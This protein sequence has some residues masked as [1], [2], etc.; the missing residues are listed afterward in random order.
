M[1]IKVKK[2]LNENCYMKLSIKVDDY[3]LHDKFTKN[4]IS[5]IIAMITGN[6]APKINFDEPGICEPGGNKKC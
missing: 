2:K 1:K 3:T 4:E 5:D 6:Y